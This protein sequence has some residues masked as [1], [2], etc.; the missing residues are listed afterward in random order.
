MPVNAVYAIQYF[1]VAISAIEP[2]E[3]QWAEGFA[4]LTVGTNGTVR[5]F[6]VFD[7]GNGPALY[8]GGDFTIAG[9]VVANRVAKWDG[10]SWSPL[11]TGVNGTVRALATYDFDGDGQNPPSLFVAGSFSIAG[12]EN[13]NHV[14][15]W[16]GTTWSPTG[17]GV[18]GTYGSVYALFVFDFDDNGPLPTLLYAGS[19]SGVGTSN[20]RVY[21]W[22]GGAW[23]AVGSMSAGVVTA[24]AASDSAAG[25]SLYAAGSGIVI[26][27]GNQYFGELVVRWNES[28]WQT[29]T[30]LSG[31]SVNALAVFDD[32]SG[33]A[34]Y[35]GGS[36]SSNIG[37]EVI[38]NIAKWNGSAWLSVGNGLSDRV[39]ALRVH[40][41]GS[42]LAL[43]ASG[44]FVYAGGDYY[45]PSRITVN[46]L[47]Q[48]DGHSWSSVDDGLNETGLALEVFDDGSGRSV[49]VGG[50]FTS[51]AGIG[52]NHVAKTNGSLLAA[53]HTGDGTSA[54]VDAFDVLRVDAR[55]RLFTRGSFRTVGNDI[56]N[57]IA[58]WDGEHWGHLAGGIANGEVRA[59]ALYDDG[60]GGGPVVI[61]AGSFTEVGGVAAQ[62]IA[63]WDGV[64][65]S[66]L[67][68]G[69]NLPIDALAVYDDGTGPQLYAA[70]DF[71]V[72]GGVPVNR[73]ARWDGTRWTS[74]GELG[75]G[76][77]GGRVNTMA[78][79]DSGSG[80]V[81]CVGGAFTS[82]NDQPIRYLAQ[83]NGV[84]WSEVGGGVTGEV[85]SL[86]V[87]SLGGGLSLFVRGDFDYA[88]GSL[89]RGI[90]RWSG[91]AWD[92]LGGGLP[93]YYWY[94]E[95]VNA[96]AVFDDG[97]GSEVYAAG[98]FTQIG[99]I[100]A[101]RI[102]K[103]DGDSW[104][105]LGNVGLNNTARALRVF[106]D[107]FGA[108]LYVAGDFT[109]AGGLA[110]RRIARWERTGWSVLDIG[111][112]SGT[113][114]NASATI[115]ALAV[116]DGAL[117]VGG[118]FET[119]GTLESRNFAHW[120]GCAGQFAAHDF[121]LDGDVDLADYV[122][123]EGCFGGPDGVY[124]PQALPNDWQT[125]AD[126]NG[127]IAADSDQDRDVD[128]RDFWMLQAQIVGP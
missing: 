19:D 3:P 14:A 71:F 4:S 44:D 77:A 25:P 89:A 85:T 90:A 21:K 58:E 99:S 31:N 62:N 35:A 36:F 10:E 33:P 49:Y 17:V 112:N 43:F 8:V 53:L 67:G 70:C 103:W 39:Y 120:D 101:N 86:D 9:G 63:K 88:G 40:E 121:D 30:Y 68:S 15:R 22:D 18:G 1:V 56:S 55:D 108:A 41:S 7:D 51:A 66:P 97:S 72:A 123:F 54:A 109:E 29:T 87:L 104:S 38:V 98:N 75:A 93:G 11:G 81:L 74:V 82:V 16:D 100:S 27:G 83:W 42:E 92:S 61:A 110:A 117:Y 91:V 125:G 124:D 23:T 116:L 13:A 64:V 80:P 20:S 24:F 46:R 48:Y 126:A 69:T 115:N 114:Y 105:S 122:L 118:A 127:F 95:T 119:A 6:T 73:I 113:D 96:L 84:N 52:A 76:L 45:S 111:I 50:E 60:L 107:G 26:P 12:N 59:T 34:L 2:C 102:A 78:V 128:L 57:G 5:A 47:A 65:W 37:G 94:G 106:D 32:G 79:F 28:T